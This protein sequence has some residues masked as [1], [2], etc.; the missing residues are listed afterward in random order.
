MNL[1]KKKGSLEDS[2][3]AAYKVRKIDL[4]ALISALGRNS[5]ATLKELAQEFNC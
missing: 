1:Q 4:Q 5:G 2:P 3:R